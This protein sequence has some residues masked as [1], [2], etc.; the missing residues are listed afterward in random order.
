MI[1]K[2]TATFQVLVIVFLFRAWNITDVEINRGV[3]LL[4]R[5]ICQVPLFTSA[6]VL[7]LY[8]GLGLKN[9][10]LFT[11][12]PVVTTHHLHHGYLQ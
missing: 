8:F 3:Q 1:L 12:L 11:S 9:L 7:V 10:V 2:D 6:V 5:K 4:R